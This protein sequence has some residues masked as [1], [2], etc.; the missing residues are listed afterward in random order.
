M[1]RSKE[2]QEQEIISEFLKRETNAIK[3]IKCKLIYLSQSLPMAIGTI[4]A[5]VVI[6][7]LGVISPATTTY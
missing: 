1:P 5:T 2:I 6:L 3:F 4:Q 7:Q